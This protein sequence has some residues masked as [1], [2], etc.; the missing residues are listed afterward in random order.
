[1]DT[2]EWIKELERS[3]SKQVA[4]RGPYVTKKTI[5]KYEVIFINET[6]RYSVSSKDEN[7]Y[8][9]S[10]GV[11]KKHKCYGKVSDWQQWDWTGYYPFRKDL[12]A[13]QDKKKEPEKKKRKRR[14]RRAVANVTMDQEHEGKVWPYTSEIGKAGWHPRV[15]PKVVGAVG[16][17][18]GDHARRDIGDLETETGDQ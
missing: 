9:S 2:R 17:A 5:G 10:K 11:I 15:N 12:Y 3:A 4:G 8:E 7:I 1:V 14:A 16:N 13:W 6:E 18:R